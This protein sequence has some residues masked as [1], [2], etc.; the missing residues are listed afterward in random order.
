[1]T[2][3][4]S[5]TPVL[6]S[7]P[8]TSSTM[9]STERSAADVDDG[10]GLR[11]ISD[12]RSWGHLQAETR[13]NGVPRSHRRRTVIGW[14]TTSDSGGRRRTMELVLQVRGKH[15]ARRMRRKAAALDQRSPPARTPSYD[16]QSLP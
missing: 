9:S 2:Y 1:M 8:T 4:L 15:G 16:C 14:T 13:A 11:T 5:I 6:A 7:I 12:A 3:V 10:D